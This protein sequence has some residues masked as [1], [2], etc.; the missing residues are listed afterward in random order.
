MRRE[1]RSVDVVSAGKVGCLWGLVLSIIIGCF[2][3]FLPAM[4]LPSLMA[5]MMPRQEEALTVFGGGLV[6]VVVVYLVYI[7]F[8]AAVITI[9]AL[10]AALVYNLIARM[11]G[12]LV[13]ETDE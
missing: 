4:V 1:I 13:V 8:N 3:I 2:A 12:G 11:A 9:G 5:S 7:V 6:G 10:L